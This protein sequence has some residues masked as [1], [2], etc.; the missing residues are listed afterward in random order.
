MGIGLTLQ[1]VEGWRGQ[2]AR[3]LRWRE[4]VVTAAHGEP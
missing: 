3:V 1:Q 2:W 4:R